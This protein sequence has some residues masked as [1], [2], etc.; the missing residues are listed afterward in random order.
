L[1]PT[2]DPTY[3]RAEIANPIATDRVGPDRQSVI[4][5]E[6]G[7]AIAR[8]EN[9]YIDA[10]NLPGETASSIL[11][12]MARHEIN[13]P[14]SSPREVGQASG[15]YERPLLR[16]SPGPPSHSEVCPVRPR[17]GRG[18]RVLRPVHREGLDGAGLRSAETSPSRNCDQR[19]GAFLLPPRQVECEPLA[20][21]RTLGR[22]YRHHSAGQHS[23]V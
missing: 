4:H 3:L 2:L 12:A 8:D 19:I 15:T 16:R 21:S 14:S 11:H 5:L 1:R 23:F 17:R 18:H 6:Q 9:D 7:H 10:I 13:L 22:Y 20:G